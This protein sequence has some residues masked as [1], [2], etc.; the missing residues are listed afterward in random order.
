MTHTFAHTAFLG[1]QEYTF[2]LTPALITELEAK[3]GSGI[4]ALCNRVF[5]RAYSQSDITETV[6]IALI[7]GSTAPK[8]A[9]ELIAAYV[10]NQPIT[11]TAELAARILE[12]T[13]FGNPH[14]TTDGQA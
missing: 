6:R 10:H 8:R 3:C 7:G 9:A 14:E 1:D 13:L 12:K 5:A 4:G 2:R 11:D